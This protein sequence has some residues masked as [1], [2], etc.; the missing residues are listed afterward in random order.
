MANVVI[1]FR[2]K[3]TSVPRARAVEIWN[4]S[5]AGYAP[6]LEVIK[7]RYYESS[8]RSKTVQRYIAPKAS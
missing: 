5:Q 4:K 6:G 7:F 2:K 3:R 8:M 1:I